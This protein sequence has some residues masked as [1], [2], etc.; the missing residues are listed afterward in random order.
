MAR[1][2]GKLIISQ[3]PR[4]MATVMRSLSASGSSPQQ[5]HQAC[6][7]VVSALVRYSID[8]N[9]SMAEAEE[10][11][12]VV[13]H[14]LVE[15]I[16]GTEENP[17]LFCFFASSYHVSLLVGKQK[18]RMEKCWTLFPK[19]PGNNKKQLFMCQ[20]CVVP[21]AFFTSIHVPILWSPICLFHKHSCANFVQPH[22]PFSQAFMCQFCAVPYAFFTS[23]QVPFL[24]S[25]ICLF[26]KP[27]C[28]IFG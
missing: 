1:V 13:G 12:R 9:T 15:A 3:L 10:V 8:S 11:V 17:F 18:I 16:A 6:A 27:S 25:P 26:H 7:K 21:Y 4:V 14:P 19:F 24:C 20:F 22:M 23:A 28:V 2:H 5:L